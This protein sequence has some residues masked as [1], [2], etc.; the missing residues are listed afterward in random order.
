MVSS[1]HM[2]LLSKTVQGSDDDNEVNKSKEFNGK[3]DFLGSFGFTR[4]SGR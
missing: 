4:V 3:H 1:N 2:K